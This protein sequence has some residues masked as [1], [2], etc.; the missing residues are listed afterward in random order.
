M[1]KIPKQEY[2]AESKGLAPGLTPEA[3][4]FSRL[5]AENA[6]LKRENETLKKATT[7]FVRIPL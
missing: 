6:W 2:T 1:K 4:A 7:Y 5:R 3:M